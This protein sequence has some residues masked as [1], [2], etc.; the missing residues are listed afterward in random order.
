MP[1]FNF[2]GSR[3]HVI[4]KE[5]NRWVLV[6]R[7]FGFSPY[8]EAKEFPTWHAAMDYAGGKTASSGYIERA[9]QPA[10]GMDWFRVN[11]FPVR[12]T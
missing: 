3:K 7:S 10:H 9:V 5:G 6:R 12:I 1:S 11:N 4:F 2:K 8:I